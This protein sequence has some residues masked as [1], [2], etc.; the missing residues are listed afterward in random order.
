MGR[1]P[2]AVSPPP[3]PC[4]TDPGRSRRPCAARSGPGRARRRRR[5]WLAPRAARRWGQ[6][7]SGTPDGPADRTVPANPDSPTAA[8]ARERL[9]TSDRFAYA[10]S[11]PGE[12][13]SALQPGVGNGDDGGRG[14]RGEEEPWPRRSRLPRQSHPSRTVNGPTA[15]LGKKAYAEELAGLQIELVKLQEWIK[16]QGLRVVVVFEGRD[17][18]GKGGTIK[19]ITQSLNPRICRV[20]ALAAPT[21]RERT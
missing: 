16:H 11:D 21:E 5:C 12:Q 19:R 17:A 2:R 3:S 9:H 10:C 4:S 13:L 7:R 18:A 1:A 15:R 20:V 6:A 14:A 8:T